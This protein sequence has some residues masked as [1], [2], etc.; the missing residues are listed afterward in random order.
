MQI[1]ETPI[2]D[3]LIIQPQVFGDD[4]GYFFESYNKDKFAELGLNI[5]F[6]QDNQS[7]S[8]KGVL[9]GLHLQNP[10]HEQGKLVRV[11]Q[12]AVLDVAVDVRKDSLTFGQHYK[13]ELTQENKT[14]FWIPPGFMHGFLTLRD[15]TIFF[16]KCT[17]FYN[18][19]SEDSVI[20]N[21]SSINIDWGVKKPI[22][23]DK[24]SQASSFKN[25]TSQF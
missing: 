3:L 15:D 9:R 11:I 17:G 23:S 14:M 20:W 8:K 21:D 5:D 24:D 4:R 2:K 19:E 12:G 22:L 7:M 25:F 6:V 1:Q 13:I 18:R 16:Y 10:P